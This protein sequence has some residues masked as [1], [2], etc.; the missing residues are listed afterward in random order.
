M[1]GSEENKRAIT[2]PSSV[3]KTPDEVIARK[4]LDKAEKVAILKQ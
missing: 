3:F 1:L 2:N 4:D